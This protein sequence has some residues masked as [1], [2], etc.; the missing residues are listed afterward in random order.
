MNL[1]LL[2]LTLVVAWPGAVLVTAAILNPQMRAKVER[3]T[4]GRS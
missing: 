2:A 1:F 3:F 4:E